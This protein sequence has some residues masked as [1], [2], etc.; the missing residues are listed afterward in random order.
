MQFQQTS[1]RTQQSPKGAPA[2]P[3][4]GAS[5]PQLRSR[6][7]GK[8]HGFSVIELM[9]ALALGLVVVTGIVNLFVGNS[10]TYT[11]LN[12]QARLQEN[13]RFGFEF[14]TRA[15]RTAGYFGCAPEFDNIVNTLN[16]PDWDSMPEFDLSQP[17]Q[18][19]EGEAGGTWAPV[20]SSLPRTVGGASA[21]VYIPGNGVDISTIVDETDVLVLRSLAPPARRLTANLGAAGNPVVEAPGNNSDFAVGDIVMIADCEQGAMFRITGAAVAANEV[22]LAHATAGT[23]VYENSATVDGPAGPI[24]RQLSVIGQPYEKDTIVAGV[25]V[26]IFFIAPSA[27]VDNQ[28]NTPNALWRKAGTDAP[29]EL[30]AGIDDLQLLYGVDSTLADG[31]PN[32]NQY[33][34]IDDVPDVNQIVSLRVTLAVNS[35]DAVTDDGSQLQR[36]FTKTILLRNA[37][38]GA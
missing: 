33:M 28:G 37:S 15:A 18:G 22:T 14:I 3:L 20:L 17:V 5:R 30:I 26:T 8:Q 31:V 24:P 1:D 21:N 11:I 34:P 32:A 12:G 35:V 38:P 10:Q 2:R 7:P 29:Q 25:E 9:L 6:Q 4:R 23:G 19:H 13:A 36:T 27:T 16:A